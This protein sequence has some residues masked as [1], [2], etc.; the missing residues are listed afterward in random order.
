MGKPVKLSDVEIETAL[1]S[2]PGWSLVKGKMHREFKFRDFVHAFAFMTEVALVAE[3]M[4]HHPEWCNV[5]NVV[6]VDLTTHDAGGLTDRDLTLARKM[7][8]LVAEM[9]GAVEQKS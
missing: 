9:R 6:Q 7:D 3:A 8:S 1:V 4:N 2:L 5:Y